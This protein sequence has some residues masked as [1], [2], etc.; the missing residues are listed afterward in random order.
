M[1]G[2]VTMFCAYPAMACK[3]KLDDPPVTFARAAKQ[4]EQCIDLYLSYPDGFGE[5]ESLTPLLIAQRGDGFKIVTKI[6]T[7]PSEFRK[8]QRLAYFCLSESALRETKIV[9]EYMDFTPPEDAWM[10]ELMIELDQLDKRLAA[11]DE[12][13]K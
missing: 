11:S 6:N 3:K 7:E 5:L 13:K 1:V 4:N 10:C 12:A 9:I 8:G 2:L